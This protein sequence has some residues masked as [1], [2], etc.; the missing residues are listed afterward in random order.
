MIM[1]Q[2]MS[3][4]A[5][6]HCA[7][8]HWHNHEHDKRMEGYGFISAI[9]GLT[10]LL[11]AWS[12]YKLAQN[13]DQ[14]NSRSF[15]VLLTF[16]LLCICC[17][18]MRVPVLY[19]LCN[20]PGVASLIMYVIYATTYK[21][22]WALLVAVIFSRVRCFSGIGSTSTLILSGLKWE[23]A[24]MALALLIAA[25][26]WTANCV[27][28]LTHNDDLDRV[29]WCL[30]TVSIGSLV[31][32]SKL[33]SIS[34]IRMLRKWYNRQRAVNQEFIELATK[35]SILSSVSALTSTLMCVCVVMVG[36]LSSDMA[37]SLMFW[38][39]SGE[40]IDVAGNCL[41][42]F[43]AIK[44]GS[45]QYEWVCGPMHLCCQGMCAAMAKWTHQRKA[46]TTTN[47]D[48][49]LAIAQCIA[50]DAAESTVESTPIKLRRSSTREQINTNLRHLQM[51][52]V[53]CGAPGSSATKS[54][55]PK[56][57]VYPDPCIP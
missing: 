55:L 53:Y 24:L 40:S 11:S 54:T 7:N 10:V 42:V 23:R 45:A 57:I 26:A 13:K 16:F 29:N 6:L 50:A 49:E 20:R 22:Q 19:A 28:L 39:F 33:L 17:S 32:C 5:D 44:I 15:V 31:I 12:V 43:L 36:L 8:Y 56:M 14:M 34:F 2:G 37:D 35:L 21:L 3:T 46:T 18:S 48:V 30:G 38:W 9:S 25:A 1:V 51:G 4:F 27:R 41:A 47:V 52:E